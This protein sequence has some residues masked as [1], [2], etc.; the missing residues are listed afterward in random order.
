MCGLKRIHRH[1]SLYFNTLN[2]IT[3]CGCDDSSSEMFTPRWVRQHRVGLCPQ[4]AP[5]ML[6]RLHNRQNDKYV[7]L[8]I[9][10]SH[11]AVCK[12]IKSVSTL[13][14]NTPNYSVWYLVLC[15]RYTSHVQYVPVEMCDILS[16]RPAFSTAA[17]ESLKE[18]KREMNKM[19][20]WVLR[21]YE[22]V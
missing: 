21:V 19:M 7:L 18:E 5:V 17:T 11:K 20:I 2:H 12:Y 10:M 1:N 6:H 22:G 15:I 13:R 16:A 9:N 3:L 4:E 14:T 8:I